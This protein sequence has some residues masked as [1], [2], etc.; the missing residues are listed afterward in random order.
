MQVLE[1]QHGRP[2]LREGEAPPGGR[3]EQAELLCARPG[4]PV[5][6]AQ[7]VDR[8]SLEEVGQG[9]GLGAEHVLERLLERFDE[10]PVGE[11]QILGASTAQ[12]LRV[13]LARARAHLLQQSRLAEAGLALH[14]HQ[15]RPAGESLGEAALEEFQLPAPPD[16]GPRSGR[17]SGR[18]HAGTGAMRRQARAA[19]GRSLHLPL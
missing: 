9:A 19:G 17:A 18:A 6:V 14:Q 10:G 4:A 2:Q 11:R 3:T 5:P 16:E 12:S 7:L 1:E 8:A 13:A 15:L